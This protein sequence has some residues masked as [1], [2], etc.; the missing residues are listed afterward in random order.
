M[1]ATYIVIKPNT[2][3]GNFT[4]CKL[5]IDGKYFPL[6]VC[7]KETHCTTVLE[8]LNTTLYMRGETMYKK[9]IA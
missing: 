2:P 9:E 3:R 5:G 1:K 6:C 4:I 8:A 7:A